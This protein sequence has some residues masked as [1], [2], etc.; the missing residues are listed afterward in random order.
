MA[1]AENGPNGFHTGKLGNVVYYK[2]NGKNVVRKIG[3][4]TKPP[5]DSQLRVR[6]E[7][8]MCSLVLRRLL[9]FINTG[10]RPQAIIAQDNAFNQAIKFNRKNIIQG[11][12]PNFQIAYDKILLSKGSLNSPEN[13][14]VSQT[15]NGLRF[16]WDT[17]PEMAWPESTDQVMMLAYFPKLEK[18]IYSLYGESRLAGSADLEISSGLQT[19]Y[20]ETYLSFVAANRKQVANSVYTGNFNKENPEFLSLNA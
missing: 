13:W 4:S 18:V 14:Q 7:T 9:D 17:H 1:I 2:V 5:T 16:E 12:Y 8:K 20:M 19:A 6:M 11:I 3:V 10:F 15:E